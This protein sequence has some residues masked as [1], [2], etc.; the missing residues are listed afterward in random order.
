VIAARL[1]QLAADPVLRARL[2]AA[3]RTSALGF[4][5]Q[6]MVSTHHDL[7]ARLAA[8]KRA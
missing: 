7:Y 4:G 8:Q 6:A 3:A 1:T 2:G 5:W